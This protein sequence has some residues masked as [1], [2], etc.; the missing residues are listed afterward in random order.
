[1]QKRMCTTHCSCKELRMKKN[2]PRILP[3]NLSRGW[4]TN[5]KIWNVFMC[6][7]WDTYHLASTSV[8]VS[9][10]VP[11]GECQNIS[12]LMFCDA[13]A[14]Y[15]FTQINGENVWYIFLHQYI[16]TT[17]VN[18]TMHTMDQ[19]NLYLPTLWIN[20]YRYVCA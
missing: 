13:L 15:T 1:M 17:T 12:N 18:Y 3:I 9:T 19:Y 20:K 6:P 2:V 16:F 7:F 14:R 5:N 4:I 11:K 8:S 10:P